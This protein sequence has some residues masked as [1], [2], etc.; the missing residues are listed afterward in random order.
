MKLIYIMGKSSSGKDTIYRILKENFGTYVLYTTRPMRDGEK[1][2]ITYNFISN[3]EMQEYIDGKKDHKVIEYRTYQTVFGPWI[4][5]TIE[6]DQFNTKNNIVTIG[7]LESYI[8]IKEYFKKNS[9]IDIIPVYIE[10]P[11]NIRLK[12]AI[13]R[14]ENGKGQYTE[15]CRRFIADNKDFSEDNLKLVGIKKRFQNINLN[16]CVNEIY[17]YIRNYK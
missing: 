14:E 2:G 7:T 4:Y 1:E 11:D 6:D 9:N 3:K 10:V 17:E 16:D 13:E 8:Q 5:A 15:L 12:R